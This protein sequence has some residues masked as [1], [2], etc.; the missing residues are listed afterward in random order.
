MWHLD[1]CTFLSLKVK[2]GRNSR[3][4]Y[5]VFH[6]PSRHSWIASLIMQL[7][8]LVFGSGWGGRVGARLIF[9]V[10]FLIF[11]S[12]RDCLVP[13]AAVF[14]SYLYF[15]KAVLRD[16]GPRFWFSLRIV[17]NFHTRC[18]FKY[19]LAP[20]STFRADAKCASRRRKTFPLLWLTA[21]VHHEANYPNEFCSKCS[22]LARLKYVDSK[23]ASTSGWD[24]KWALES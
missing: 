11:F 5:R 21:R 12:M 19:F 23:R 22:R 16:N 20:K 7:E 8:Q 15:N 9:I 3:L 17:G 4:L 24:V 1:K 13:R 6:A 14:K 10:T 18:L 2:T